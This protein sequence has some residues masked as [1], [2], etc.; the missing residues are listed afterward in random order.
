MQYKVFQ[1]SDTNVKKYVF[2]W[3]KEEDTGIQSKAAIAEAVL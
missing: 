2:E 3:S 1:S